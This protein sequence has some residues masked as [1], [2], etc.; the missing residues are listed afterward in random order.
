MT[1]G[2][3]GRPPAVRDG[4]R[5][6]EGTTA[7]DPIART[8]GDGAEAVPPT[9]EEAPMTATYVKVIVVEIVTLAALWLFQV[10]F[11]GP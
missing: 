9:L 2:L 6:P 1:P 11:G 8:L 7:G 3:P 4:R 10:V 5:V